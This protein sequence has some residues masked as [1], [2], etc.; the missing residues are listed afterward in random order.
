MGSDTAVC[1]AAANALEYELSSALNP[2][3]G[4]PM[5]SET[6]TASTLTLTLDNTT[7]GRDFFLEVEPLLEQVVHDY[8]FTDTLGESVLEK[9]AAQ[10]VEPGPLPSSTGIREQEEQKRASTSSKEGEEGAA[11]CLDDLDSSAAAT[12]GETE[13]TTTKPLSPNSLLGVTKYDSDKVVLMLKERIQAIQ[14]TMLM[15][16]SDITATSEHS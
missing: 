7:P 5:S 16:T 11:E 14:E 13:T 6:T 2:G 10:E 15:A 9:E 8:L 4:E 3:G 12:D 1:T